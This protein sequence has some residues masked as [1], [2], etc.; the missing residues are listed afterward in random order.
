M[1]WRRDTGDKYEQQ[2][3]RTLRK[4]G[5][6]LVARNFN[7]RFGELDL[8]MREGETLVFIEVRYRRGEDFGG[9]LLSVTHA[10][11]Q[12][13]IRAARLYLRDNPAL[14]QQPCRFDVLA[15]AGDESPQRCQWV[16]HAFEAF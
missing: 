4:S 1:A 12:R 16:R 2:A 9:A 15:F 11:Q 5:L 7:T 3:L 8:I 13:L 6:K 10:K 14:A